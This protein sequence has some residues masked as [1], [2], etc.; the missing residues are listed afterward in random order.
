MSML[1]K[2]LAEHEGMKSVIPVKVRQ[3]EEKKEEPEVSIGKLNYD[4]EVDLDTAEILVHKF[5][6][7]EEDNKVSKAKMQIYEKKVKIGM[8]LRIRGIK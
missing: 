5:V 2:I 4:N 1:E 7:P 6:A 3:E 8:I